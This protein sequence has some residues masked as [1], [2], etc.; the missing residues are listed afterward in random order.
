MVNHTAHQ[1]R[2]FRRSKKGKPFLAG[3]R[4]AAATADVS[5]NIKKQII[6]EN[7]EQIA[8]ELKRKKSATIPRLGTLKLEVRSTTKNRNLHHRPRRFM[9]RF[10]AMNA[11]KEAIAA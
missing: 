9:V 11:L 2:H 5:A 10:T 8:E 3:R 1:I 7:A 4:K 6:Q